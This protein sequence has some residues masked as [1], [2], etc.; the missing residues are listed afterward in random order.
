MEDTLWEND[1]RRFYELDSKGLNPYSNGRYSLKT[2]RVE[3]SYTQ[4]ELNPCFDGRI[5]LRL[6]RVHMK[7]THTLQNRNPYSN[8]R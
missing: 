8:G 5:P 2:M 1:E 4:E 6:E 7:E 3:T